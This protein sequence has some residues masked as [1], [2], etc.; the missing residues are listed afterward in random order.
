MYVDRNFD[1]AAAFPP[2]CGLLQF[3]KGPDAND[4]IT[5]STGGVFL[6]IPAT[7]K[8]PEVVAAIMAEIW[9]AWDVEEENHV[10]ESELF[11]ELINKHIYG[12]NDIIT[13]KEAATR[14][15]M[16]THINYE[17]LEDIISDEIYVKIIEENMP[18][19]TVIESYKDS[20]QAVIDGNIR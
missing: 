9:D 6:A 10:S 19:V 18:V 14:Q 16:L 1:G 20:V 4:Y 15:H 5:M 11:L 7:T 3:P 2:N 8:N 12:P 13:C 17:G